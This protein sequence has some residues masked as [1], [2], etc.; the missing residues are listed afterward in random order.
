MFTLPWRKD[1]VRTILGLVLVVGLL[2]GG[3]HD[4]FFHVNIAHAANT[5]SSAVYQDLNADG[6]VD[7]IRITFDENVTGCTYEAG[8]WGITTA[9]TIN[10]TAVTGISCTGT[11]AVLNVAITANANVTGGVT[12]PTITYTDQG[13]TGS[14][15][16]A[17]GALTAKTISP[18]DGAPPV[19]L[20]AAYS[21]NSGCNITFSPDGITLTLSADSGTVMTWADADWTITGGGM[22]LTNETSGG[23]TG[24]NPNIRLALTATP[25]TTGS[26]GAAPTVAYTNNANRVHDGAGNNLASFS[27][28]TVTDGASPA[29]ISANYLDVNGDGRIDAVR[30]NTTADTSLHCQGYSSTSNF[31][32]GTAGTVGVTS[33]ATDTCSS[34]GTNAFTVSLVSPGAVHTTG[35]STAPVVTYTR[36]GAG[37]G[38]LDGAGNNIATTSN[39]T[40]TDAAAPVPVSAVYQDTNGDGQVDRIQLTMSSDTGLSDSYSD[41]DWTVG[42]GTVGLANETNVTQS[43]NVLT[44]LTS[45]TASMTGGA[46]NPT[47]AYTNNSNRLQDTAGNFTPTFSAVTATDSAAPVIISTTPANN[48]TN[49]S[50]SS[51]IVADFSESVVPATCSFS[52]TP[53]P[54]GFA[55]ITN[56]GNWSA[57]SNGQSSSRVTLSHTAYAGSASVTAA[58]TNCADSS[59][60][61]L[62]TGPVPSSWTFTIA[63]ASDVT[64]PTVSFTAPASGA[65]VSG[66]SV[67]LAANASDNVAVASV[68]FLIGSTAISTDSSSPYTATLDSTAFANGSYTLSAVARDTAGNSATTTESVTIS[69]ADVTPPTVS[70]TAPAS[71]ATVSGSSVSLA[72]NASD[73]VAVASVQFLIGST[74]I[75]TDSSSPYT[76]TLD[77]TAFASGSYTLSAVARDTSG[78]SATTTESVTVSNAAPAGGGG[79]GGSSYMPPQAPSISVTAPS[80]GS[81]YVAGSSASILWNALNASYA[82]FSILFS[83]DLGVLWT[84]VNSHVDGVARSLHWSVP[85]SATTTQAVVRIVGFDGQGTQLAAATGNAFTIFGTAPAAE[86]PSSVSNLP[87]VATS[88]TAYDPQAALAASVSI[89][90]DKGLSSAAAP[91]ACQPGSLIKG[92]LPAVY[93]CG[94]DGKRWVFPNE[95]AFRTWY[96]DFS[97]VIPV[98]DE[99]LSSIPLGG[100]VTYRPGSRMIKVQSD[101]KVYVVDYNGILHWV[102]TED[103]ARRLYGESWKSKIDD[104]SDAF[105]VNYR[106][107]DSIGG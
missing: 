29:I 15:T 1:A 87:P 105:F 100:N 28:K 8:D 71:G 53:D 72:A 75:S 45:G 4:I 10:V 34:N 20:S 79:G 90:A 73:N 48:A 12:A 31:S 18:T 35:G 70:F 32:V 67:S 26:S 54:G 99:I 60:N 80:S 46:S 69:N 76:A 88:G 64:P 17:S 16:L 37:Q 83:P 96:Q 6:R 41:G 63:A 95:A 81:S 97:S 78:N 104:I 43:G 50:A 7:N 58:V 93:Y 33:S 23:T 89:D 40:V 30:F 94:A 107:S 101:P 65:T 91:G 47:I 3:L 5:V 52:S 39:I 14:V 66:G 62:G 103:V 38:F 36:I 55:A 21:C 61:A 106:V 2:C 9:G 59:S 56:S 27:A 44:V 51:N 74:S 77:S 24:S 86:S 25:L 68:Q 22:A 92:S 13:T 98:S 85:A 49:V 19:A 82:Y 84:A 42:A 11:D 57:G 102:E